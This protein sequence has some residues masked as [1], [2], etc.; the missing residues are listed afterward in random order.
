M[1][2]VCRSLCQ[3]CWQ[4]SHYSRKMIGI[5][6]HVRR[7]CGIVTSPLKCNWL[8]MPWCMQRLNESQMIGDGGHFQEAV[9][10][11]RTLFWENGTMSNG[12]WIS[13]KLI[14]ISNFKHVKNQDWKR[15]LN[16]I[17]INYVNGFYFQI[18]SCDWIDWIWM[19]TTIFQLALHDGFF[20]HLPCLDWSQQVLRHATGP[21]IFTLRK[22]Q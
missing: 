15:H 16:L 10:G 6:E 17:L 19:K 4:V 21:E 1:V 2:V 14:T 12:S 8:C 7:V 20:F 9:I 3:F 5:T 13:G 18:R 22:H 11:G